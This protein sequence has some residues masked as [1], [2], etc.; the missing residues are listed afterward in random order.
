MYEH[1]ILVSMKFLSKGGRETLPP[2][3]DSEYTYRPIFKLDGDD[4]GYCCGIVIGRYIENYR[5]DATLNNVK[6]LFLEFEKVKGKLSVGQSFNLYEGNVLIG[7]GA[8][9]SIQSNIL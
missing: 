3:R 1:D 9:T 5:F 7:N 4:K 6:V 8:I 2:I